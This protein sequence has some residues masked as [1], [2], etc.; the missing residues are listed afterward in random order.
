MTLPA[1]YS[2]LFALLRNVLHAGDD[3]VEI[4]DFQNLIA[5]ARK[6]TV[7]GMLYGLQGMTL[8]PAD[9]P[10]KVA[11][12]GG[13]PVL[14]AQGQWM[15]GQVADLA[16]LLDGQHIRYAVM[17]GQTC[18]AYYPQ[19]HHRRSGDIDLYVPPADFDRAN[20]LM[21]AQGFRLTDKTMQ[22]TTYIKEQLDVEVHFAIQKLQWPVSHR[23]LREITAADF[24]LCPPQRDCFVRIGG[25]DVRMLPPELNIVLLT[26]HAFN[27]VVSGGLGLRQIVD[28]QVVLTG[29]AQKVDFEKLTVYLRQ[30][31]LLKM[32]CVLGY[33]NVTYLG[34]PAQFFTQRGF[35]LD[36]PLVHRLGERLLGWV[37][38]CG[39]FG[40]EM[41]LG[42]GTAY[43]LRYYGL[44]A[45]NLCRF[46]LLNPL[47][48]LAWPGM[49][50]YRALTGKNHLRQNR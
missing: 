30:L 2:E 1:V 38:V 27:H 48:M 34:M 7:D 25:Y 35:D 42:E 49:K 47:E 44:F 31:H 3:E 45:C 21:L 43:F 36:R 16:R 14:E 15:D 37:R 20:A 17:K 50:L 6:Q 5:T 10:K 11:W 32:F 8:R 9:R 4:E 29:T 24:D 28:W 33:L 46:F 39:N 13:L 23:R 41:N 19:P 22:H 18:A 40:K 26:A 12:I